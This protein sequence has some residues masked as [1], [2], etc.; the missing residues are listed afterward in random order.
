MYDHTK[1]ASNSVS[2]P[3]DHV[4]CFP[5][6][7]GIHISLPDLTKS[8]SKS[9][10]TPAKLPQDNTKSRNKDGGEALTKSTKLNERNFVSTPADPVN[11]FP[12]HAVVHMYMSGHTKSASNSVSTPATF[13]SAGGQR[14]KP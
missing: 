1:S 6:H 7:A 10:T 12:V 5:V 4:N 3:P 9:V 14:Q 2:T 11:C 8:T 13:P